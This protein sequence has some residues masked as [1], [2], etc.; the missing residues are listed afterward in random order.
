[1]EGG[2]RAQRRRKTVFGRSGRGR[3]RRGRSEG[4]NGV[5]S[6][7]GG[8]GGSGDKG[9]WSGRSGG[10]WRDLDAMRAVVMVVVVVDIVIVIVIGHGGNLSLIVKSVFWNNITR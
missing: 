10:A 6:G 2:F 9:R 1:M 7:G 3:W 8:D 5:S 4:E